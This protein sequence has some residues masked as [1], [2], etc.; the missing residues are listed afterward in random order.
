[1]S[2]KT[3]A[4]TAPNANETDSNFDEM[5]TTALWYA[6]GRK[7]AD[8]RFKHVEPACF[9][10]AYR[11]A[12]GM[13]HDNNQGKSTQSKWQGLERWFEKYAEYATV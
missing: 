5:F 1:M 6:K 13:W 3:A 9:A 4:K 2:T 12:Y 7:D 10:F 8:K 11:Q